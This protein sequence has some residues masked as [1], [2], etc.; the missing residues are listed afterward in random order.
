MLRLNN[1]R[2]SY[3]TAGF[4]Q[5][6]LDGVSIAFR[7]NEFAAVLGPSG[8][9]KT[10]M[11][12]IV[13]GLDRYDEGD[14]EIDNIS[15]NK[16]KASD[17]DTYRNNRIGFVFQSYNLIPHQSVL[18][19]VELALTLSG[20]SRGERK[21]R[22]KDALTQ[23]GLVD[24]IRKKPGQLSGGQMQRVAIARAL[25]NDPEILL[26]DEPTG[27]LDSTTSKQV[28]ELL[29]Q[30]AKNRLVIM[31][32][33]NNELAEKYANRI[34]NLKDGKV[35]SD[36]RPY[37]PSVEETRIGREPRKAGMS[38]ITAITLSFSNLMTKKGRTFTTAFAGSIGIIGIATILA[39]SNGIN[40]YIRNIEEETLSIYPLMIQDQ[41]FN[42]SAFFGGDDH[43]E[44]IHGQDGGRRE[45]PPNTVR[46]MQVMEM[47]FSLQNNNDL[48]S[49][50][51]YLEENRETMERY[52]TTIHYMFDVTPQI[53][54][55]DT[56]KGADQIHPDSIFSGFMGSSAEMGPQAN[57]GLMP[58]MNV[59]SELPNNPDLYESQYDV[60]AGRWPENYDEAVLVLSFGGRIMDFTLFSMGIRDREEMRAMLESVLNRTDMEIDITDSD[61]FWTYDE[62]MTSFK[63]IHPTDLFRYDDTF[64][65]WVDRSADSEFMEELVQNG[66]DLNIVGIVQPAQD[67][68][69]TVLSV[70]VNYTPDLI[71]YL[72]QTAADSSIVKE[73]LTDPKLNVIS[74]NT[75]EHERENPES[76]FDF[77]RI[78]SID[79]QLIQDAM[80]L[81][82]LM[83]AFDFENVDLGDLDLSGIDMGGFDLGGFD[84]SNIDFGDLDMSDFDL[85]NIDFDMNEIMSNIDLS[86]VE[87]PALDLGALTAAIASQVNIPP[88]AIAS[89]MTSVMVDF[90]TSV[91]QPNPELLANQ[92]ALSAAFIQYM[93]DPA[94]QAQIAAELMQYIDPTTIEDEIATAVQAYMM[95]AM[96]EYMTQIS[97]LIAA[98]MQASI[99]TMMQTAMQGIIESIMEQITS[100]IQD[101]TAQM[102]GQMASQMQRMM[103]DITAQIEKSMQSVFEQMGEEMQAAMEAFDSELLA[104]AF[105]FELSEEAIFELM[106]AM[107][108][109]TTTSYEQNLSMFGYADAATPNQILIYP[110]SFEAKQSTLDILDNYNARMEESGHPEKVVHFTDIVGLM[111]STVTD[112]IDMVSYALVS[113]VSVA[114]IVS[115]IMIGVITFISV[116]ERKKEIGIL[117]A[118]GASK[119][120]IRLVFNAETLIIGFVAGVIGVFATFLIAIVANMIILNRL[121]I[122]NLVL[123]PPVVPIILVAISMFLTY[124]AGLLP[125]SA[126]ASKPPVDALRSE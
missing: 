50:K 125:A 109:P 96:Q 82:G 57:M 25:I 27:A 8:S 36:S 4:T 119:G 122:S 75:F 103:R 70:G 98:Q 94:V 19:N 76:S 40:T 71:Q 120:N 62:L 72:M 29:T 1:I 47:M 5:N 80:N 113:F 81:E 15:T 23:V 105:Q 54:L 95:A 79:E 84:F 99:Q 124:I 24:H 60:L 87:P 33:H 49:L 32:T 7:E 34:I 37:D 111:M 77:S 11:L 108:N 90:F 12:N 121:G 101:S 38:F 112:I 93:N 117:R 88:Q 41:G 55:R 28:M 48:A 67:A 83:S 74:G 118:V 61:G 92:E 16:Y 43:D 21:R 53:F 123:M 65:V 56:S 85:S 14:L 51:V 78:M 110:R 126:A 116:L 106:M 20:V 89:I 69:T 2:K 73:Q 100:A 66:F 13:G 107:M 52:T 22:A 115:S 104:D 91:V 102:S 10:T 26:A 114:L 39:F 45:R 46:E 68:N 9:G 64:N 59:F 35:A 42:I 17:W 44:I 30:I 18:A 86:T 58:G 63:I 6:A 31:V 3:T 97:A